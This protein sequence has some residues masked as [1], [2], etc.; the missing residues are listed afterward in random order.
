MTH[1][2]L[3]ALLPDAGATLLRCKA[4]SQEVYGLGFCPRSPGRLV[5]CGTGH[6]RFWTM[7]STFT[8]LKLQVGLNQGF[9]A[10]RKQQQCN[11]SFIPANAQQVW[12]GGAT[13]GALSS[14]AAF[15]GTASSCLIF[16]S[17][18]VP[19]LNAV[20]LGCLISYFCKVSLWPAGGAGPIWWS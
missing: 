17:S 18:E 5:S 9:R 14:G 8:G 6:I 19:F 11:I 7:A 16:E 12:G 4:F 20:R 2:A 1:N 13:A 10:K 15:K 3:P